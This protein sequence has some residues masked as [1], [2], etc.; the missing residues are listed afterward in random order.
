MDLSDFRSGYLL[1]IVLLAVLYALLAW[2]VLGFFSANGVISVLWPSSGL[3]LA[4][5]LLGGMRLWP[6]I[7]LGALVANLV[8]GSPA[9]VAIAIAVGNTLEA[10]TGLLLLT[11]GKGFDRQLS[12]TS[13]YF[14]LVLLAGCI[15]TWVS[16]V[17]GTGSLLLSGFLSPSDYWQNLQ[18]WWMGDALGVVL[19]TPLVLIW[20]HRPDWLVAERL[21]E[22]VLFFGLAFLAGQVIFLDWLHGWFGDINR[23][24]WMFLFASV[25][26]VRFGQHG[27]LLIVGMTVIQALTGAA[28]GSGFFDDDMARTQLV[29][30]W[31]YTV[32]LLVVGMAQATAIR[33]RENQAVTDSLTR[34][35]NRL[36]FQHQL[37][38]DLTRARN[39]GR[40]LALLFIDIDRFKDVNDTLGHHVGDVLLELTATRLREF[41]RRP[42]TV[43][44]LGGDEF[45]VILPELKDSAHAGQVASQILASLNE[46]F[47]V[48]NEQIYVSGSI[49]ITFFP[50]DG[51]SA[52]DLLRHADQAMYT[53]KGQGRNRFSFFTQQIQQAEELRVR[54]AGDMRSALVSGQF[55][56]CYQPVV[57]LDTGRTVKVEAL[58]RW[59]HPKL[60]MVSPEQ[61][62]PVAEETGLIN[63]IGDWVISEAASRARSWCEMTDADFQVSVNLSPVQFLDAGQTLSSGQGLQRLLSSG[64]QLMVE[65]T[66]GVLLDN[67]LEVSETLAE[68]RRAGVKVAV[69]DFGTGYSSLSYLR[70]FAIDYLKIDRSFTGDIDTDG[71]TR[72]L[73]AAII[74]MAHALGLKVIAE[75]IETESQ[76]QYLLE[77]GCD[78]GQGYHYARPVPGDEITR[79]LRDQ[80]IG[81]ERALN[82]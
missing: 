58:L 68:L 48:G 26:A 66:E 30:F 38:R 39:S 71:T 67:R 56:L 40:R 7:L 3:S 81:S 59:R 80:Q 45:T 17:I 63:E 32:I 23:G 25:A 53:A 9:P 50:D 13:D 29:N 57:E 19:F 21:V 28:R 69:D 76:G 70:T 78:Y 31:G 33:Q 5:L 16:A 24:F 6:G 79:L 18:F 14:R 35:P 27:A 82:G 54:L 11:A 74:R 49:G 72:E 44:R 62:I 22:V 2:V 10:V 43:A 34:L 4:A 60:G 65:I 15:S 36:W 12:T 73:V 51:R 47:H 64:D 55:S 1:K 20:R 42:A 61:F 75:G 37:R 77:Q 46:P 8:A 41:I 52:A